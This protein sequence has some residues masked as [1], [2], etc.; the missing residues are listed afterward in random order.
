[1]TKVLM[2]GWEFPPQFTGGLGIATYG[3]VKAL[4]P[5]TSI[6]LIIP[7]SPRNTDLHSVDITGLN[8]IAVD[9]DWEI[10]LAH[11][12]RLRVSR[13]PVAL[14][15]YHEV[16]RSTSSQQSD[17]ISNEKVH[18]HQVQEYIQSLFN[19]NE[20]YGHRIQEKIALYS[21]LCEKLAKDRNFDV[22]HAHDWLTFPAAVN[23]KSQC[24]KPLVLHVHALETDRAGESA[25]NDIFH[26]EKKA[27]S[28][29]DAIIAVSHYTK[30][31]LVN[32]YDVAAEKIQVI[33]N[34]ID[35]PLSPYTRKENVLRDKLVVF[36]GRLTYQKGPFFLLETA[37]KVIKVFPRVKF[38]V[39]GTGDQFGSLIENVA[40]KKLGKH[41]IFTGFLHKPHVNELL[42]MADVYF[43]PS[44]S[45]PFGL[46]ALEAAQHDVPTVVSR[47]C[48]AHEAMPSGFCADF[49]DTD[50]YANYIVALLKYGK[51]RDVMIERAKE[52][53]KTLTWDHAAIKITRL[54]NMFLN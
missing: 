35:T 33:H 45:E 8:R 30:G 36:L 54:Y 40:Y 44:V 15:P 4:L 47:Q 6:R 32:L 26:I 19:D 1:M 52:E 49:W 24:D 34:G 20:V 5:T 42:S 11:I 37:E 51:L 22:I 21:I 18:H 27:F 29:A 7:V 3:I 50:K 10:D 48:G 2:L 13:I 28:K 43:M 39:A 17:E 14:S 23:I 9:Q 12:E 31:Q 53:L 46:A 25:R 41:F 38:V 16:N